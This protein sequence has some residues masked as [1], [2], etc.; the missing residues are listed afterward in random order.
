M[1]SMKSLS[2]A[3]LIFVFIIGFGSVRAD[4]RDLLKRIE[5]LWT[6]SGTA[7]LPFLPFTMDVEGTANFQFDSVCDCFHTRLKSTR[8][9]IPYSDSGRLVHD[10]LTDSIFWEVKDNLGRTTRTAGLILTSAANRMV[11]VEKE[12][13]HIDSTIVVWQHPDT[14]QVIWKSVDKKGHCEQKALLDLFRKKQ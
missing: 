12:G 3:L 6:G 1:K 2:W 14:M 5:G 8:K 11:V 10:R 7:D 13:R 9:L 4:Q